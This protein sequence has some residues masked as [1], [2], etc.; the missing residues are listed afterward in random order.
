MVVF[1]LAFVIEKS[2]KHK[3]LH[4]NIQSTG[5]WPKCFRPVFTYRVRYCTLFHTSL[6]V[7]HRCYSQ[8]VFFFL[9]YFSIPAN[10]L[11]CCVDSFLLM[12]VCYFIERLMSQY[13]D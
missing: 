4:Q 9:L 6:L 12:H 10:Q 5:H 7:S 11:S 8:A 1:F 13:I 2:G 3:N